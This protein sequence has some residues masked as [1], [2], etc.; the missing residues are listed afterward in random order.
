MQIRKLITGTLFTAIVLIAL[1]AGAQFPFPPPGSSGGT[2][3]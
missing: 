2:N 1:N 3:L